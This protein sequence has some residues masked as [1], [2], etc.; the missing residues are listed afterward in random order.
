MLRFCY[1]ALRCGHRGLRFM[2]IVYVMLSNS[3]LSEVPIVV[4][5]HP[6]DLCWGHVLCIVSLRLYVFCLLVVLVKLLVLAK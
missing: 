2:P 3:Y 5:C 6:A 4:L 1:D